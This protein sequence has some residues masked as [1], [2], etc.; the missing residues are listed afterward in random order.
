MIIDTEFEAEEEVFA[1]KMPFL[2][3]T[4]LTGCDMS[5]QPMFE[6][7]DEFKSSLRHLKWLQEIKEK[8]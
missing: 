3:A 4:D 2:M 7:R 1:I 5:W 8:R 6:F